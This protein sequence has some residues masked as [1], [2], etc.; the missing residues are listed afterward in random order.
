MGS[1]S[2]PS[3]APIPKRVLMVTSAL[4]MGGCERQILATAE[5]LI[6]LG[7]EI[8]IFELAEIH[9]QFGLDDEFWKL[10]ITSRTQLAHVSLG[11]G[12][13]SAVAAA[14]A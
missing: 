12:E 5:G 1:E 13:H 10:G 8:E 11:E 2:R 7:Y 9:S 6:P 14:T 3:F 4:A